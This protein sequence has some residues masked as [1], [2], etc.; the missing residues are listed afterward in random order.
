[1]NESAAWEMLEMRN[2]NAVGSVAG[3]DGPFMVI[4]PLGN[5]MSQLL[6][7]LPE[8][9]AHSLL[10]FLCSDKITSNLENNARVGVRHRESRKEL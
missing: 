4:L 7:N 1:M 2:V 9:R 10:H 6:C 3:V 8:R 5:N